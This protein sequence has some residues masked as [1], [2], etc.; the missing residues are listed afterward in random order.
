MMTSPQVGNAI[1]LN[2]ESLWEFYVCRDYGC[3]RTA[4][5]MLRA[6]DHLANLRHVFL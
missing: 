3:D 6:C 1:T 4:G 5:I 2:L